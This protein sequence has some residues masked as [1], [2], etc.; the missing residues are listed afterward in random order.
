M[1]MER[2]LFALEPARSI[3]AATF[4]AALAGALQHAISGTLTL[5]PPTLRNR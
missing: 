1:I 5:H 3:P 4:E 2:Y